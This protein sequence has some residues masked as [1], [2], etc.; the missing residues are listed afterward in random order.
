M[1]H[2]IGL[3]SKGLLEPFCQELIEFG[4]KKPITKNGGVWFESSWKDL[5]RFSLTSRLVH[6][7]LLPLKDFQAYNEEDLYSGMQSIDFTKRFD[8]NHTFSI[9]VSL[10]DHDHLR[11]QRFVAMKCKDA[12][13]D[14][15]RDKFGERPNVDR[16]RPD[17]RVVVRLQGPK[18]SVALDMIGDSLSQ[19][20]YRR[21]ALEAPLRETLAYGLL[22]M[23]GWEPSIPL[24]DPMCGSGTI[25]IEAA[26]TA[27]SMPVH[28]HT[29]KFLF[30][31]LKTFDP[32]IFNS[33]K[34]D[35]AKDQKEK[36]RAI[37][38]NKRPRIIGFD[39]DPRA[40][41]TAQE[42]A[43]KAGVSKW[44]DFRVGDVKDLVNLTGSDQGMIITN[45]PY[46][47][48]LLDRD[49]IKELASTFA[50]SLK[51]N[52]KGWDVWTLSGAVEWSEGLH[53]KSSKTYRVNNG[54]LE[55]RFM[56]YEIR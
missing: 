32:D 18:V 15:F 55:V 19:R 7:F 6:R 13:V 22:K 52:F 47:E 54:P 48:R 53:L 3:S 44:I 36:S 50:T 41:E 2:F 40:I 4:A 56:R 23:S 51:H 31:K 25:L 5:Y 9:Q 27:L 16:D 8:V 43:L 42:N 11:D 33:V 30:Q 37:L 39:K 49:R 1:P 34:E 24:I 20:G 35:I 14:Q 21:D 38:K 17:Y 46:G 10:K 26:R 29:P 45:P 12:I 28:L